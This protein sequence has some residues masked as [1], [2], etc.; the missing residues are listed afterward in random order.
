MKEPF[1][2]LPENHE[3]RQSF[4]EL[5][6]L[7]HDT[8][9]AYAFEKQE[10]AFRIRSILRSL[11]KLQQDREIAHENEL[12]ELEMTAEQDPLT[13]LLNKRAW[14]S[15]IET[16]IVEGETDF[17]IIFID[18]SRFKSVNDTYDHL[19]GDD[20]LQK[21]ASVIDAS[22]RHDEDY[23]GYDT[24]RYGG[25]EFAILCDLKSREN[26]TQE[27]LEKMEIIT[28]RLQEN[29]RS[30]IAEEN[31][32]YLHV[33]AAIG[34]A[35]YEPDMDAE[36]LIRMADKA[37]YADKHARSVDLTNEETIRLKSVKPILDKAG[38]RLPEG[39]LEE[40]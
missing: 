30:L 24:G 27:P 2:Q 38:V 21:T 10:E 18:L 26:S 6:A 35:L 20:L 28:R 9:A 11:A 37:M 17:G 8:L 25:D 4:E 32:A 39:I 23:V 15:R 36:D 16:M 22:L 12:I 19:R 31:L 14:V 33:D 34:Y 7:P 40:Y 13:G 1:N 3:G 29:F 5:A